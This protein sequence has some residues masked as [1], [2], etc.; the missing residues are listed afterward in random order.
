MALNKN[1]ILDTP[2]YQGKNLPTLDQ[3][4]G[5]VP[6]YM[7]ALKAAYEADTNNSQPA[8]AAPG[9]FTTPDGQQMSSAG[10]HL[11]KSAG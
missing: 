8:Y 6:A 2:Q 9:N 10:Y 11:D 7:A 3:Y 5:D 1:Y 4:G